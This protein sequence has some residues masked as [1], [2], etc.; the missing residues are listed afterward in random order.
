MPSRIGT[1]K[2]YQRYIS[3]RVKKSRPD[4]KS[5]SH[6][7]C[8]KTGS[9]SHG[10]G[11]SCYVFHPEKYSKQQGICFQLLLWQSHDVFVNTTPGLKNGG[12]VTLDHLIKET[13]LGERAIKAKRWRDR[14]SPTKIALKYHPFPGR[15]TVDGSEIPNNHLEC[16][17]PC[18]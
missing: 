4:I 6:P 8:S 16:I 18:E 15:I 10:L 5:M 13:H 17:K 7:S 12:M 11:N 3:A 2:I 14:I 1:E 9:L